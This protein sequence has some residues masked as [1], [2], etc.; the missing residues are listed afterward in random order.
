MNNDIKNFF[1]GIEVI[2]FNAE[3]ERDSKTES[4]L[5]KGLL[6]YGVKK[7]YIK[8]DKKGVKNA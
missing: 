2:S 6:N 8:Q 3:G 4:Q 5:K 1:G 7:G